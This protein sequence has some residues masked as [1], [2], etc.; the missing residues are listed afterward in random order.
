MARYT[1]ASCRLCRREKQK[2]FLKGAKCPTEKCPFSRRGF[3]PGQHGATQIR[4]KE[5]N[6]GVQLREKQK[7]KRLYGLLERQFKHYFRMAERA[8]GVT[9][10]TL[11]QLLERRLD[12]V[13]FRMNLAGSRAEARQAVQHGLVYVNNKRLDIPSYIVALGDEIALKPKKEKFTKKIKENQEAFKERAVPKWLQAVPNE[14]KSKVVAMPTKDDVGF[15]IQ[16]QLIV[17]LYSK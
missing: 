13:I 5:S 8:K 15:P 4:K 3:P 7:V 11:L 2:L 1:D 10:L 17:E 6:Y 14:F 9:G 16:E 12:N